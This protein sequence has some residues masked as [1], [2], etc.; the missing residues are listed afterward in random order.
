MGSMQPQRSLSDLG[1]GLRREKEA[2][3][4]HFSG[5]HEHVFLVLAFFGAL[6]LVLGAS[7][8][9]DSRG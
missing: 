1:P 7:R 3:V 8:K 5:C 9:E 6:L 2:R 4:H